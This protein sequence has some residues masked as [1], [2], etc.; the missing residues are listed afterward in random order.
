VSLERAN[1]LVADDHPENLLA[2]EQI[3]EP[4]GQTVVTA[5]SGEDV[6]RRLLKD[7]FAV[8]LLDVQMPRMGGFEVAAEIKS[9]ERTRHIPIIFLT[10][11]SQAPQD[12]LE[13]YS[14]GAVDYLFKPFEPWVLRAKVA[15]FLDI[16]LEHKRTEE[17]SRQ[18]AALETRRHH[19]LE[20][21]ESIVQG[22]AVAK[23]ALDLGEGPQAHAAIETTLGAAK[24]VMSHLLADDGDQTWVR[25]GDLRAPPAPGP[26][27]DGNGE[28]R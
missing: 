5:S 24:R 28:A 3:L 9:R 8:I 14:A 18:L 25:P 2:L 26:E 1:I 13:G 11:V 19:A 17:L 4:L 22:L 23:L 15:V 7:E 20:L 10:A 12:E 21:N 27:A 16:Y 6:L